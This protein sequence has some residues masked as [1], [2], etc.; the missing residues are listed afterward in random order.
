MCRHI[1][2]VHAIQKARGT[3]DDRTVEALLVNKKYTFRHITSRSALNNTHE[4]GF[5]IRQEKYIIIKQIN[6][7]SE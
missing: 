6:D 2:T 3:T 7:K 5:L 1:L 4:V